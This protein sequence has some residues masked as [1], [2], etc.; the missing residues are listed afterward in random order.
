MTWLV[1]RQTLAYDGEINYRFFIGRTQTDRG[2]GERRGWRLNGV[3]CME[4]NPF[5]HLGWREAGLA[6]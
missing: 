6:R 4:G 3:I 5:R 2:E 1:A